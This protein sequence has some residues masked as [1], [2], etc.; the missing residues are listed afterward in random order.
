MFYF[1]KARVLSCSFILLY[2]NKIQ[3]LSSINFF[4][5]CAESGNILAFL[6]LNKK[7]KNTLAVLD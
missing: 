7:K 6:K 3:M 2:V 5:M 4:Q 1:Y